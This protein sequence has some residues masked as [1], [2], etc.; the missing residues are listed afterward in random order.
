MVD[1]STHFQQKKW[2]S[3]AVLGDQRNQG[4]LRCPDPQAQRGICR[5]LRFGFFLAAKL[6]RVWLKLRLSWNCL[7]KEG[8][9]KGTFGQISQQT[10]KG[11]LSS[12]D[13]LLQFMSRV[14]FFE[15]R[16]E[17]EELCLGE[18]I[19]GPQNLLSLIL[20][21]QPLLFEIKTSKNK[22]TMSTT[23]GW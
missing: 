22:T 9:K 23:R 18:E 7:H 13:K 8:L 21:H 3:Y 11:A 19:A 10:Q 4:R 2:P 12:D 1:S 16:H 6:N 5:T 20:L 17:Q 14:S 15:A